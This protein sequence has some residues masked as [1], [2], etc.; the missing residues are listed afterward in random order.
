MYCSQCGAKAAGK[1]CSGCGAPLLA[2]TPG[3]E[4][5]LVDWKN[6]LDY[7][8]LLRVPEVR[9]RIARSAAQCKRHMTGEQFLDICEKAFGKFAGVPLPFATIAQFAQSFHARLGIKTGKSRSQHFTRPPGE[10]LVAILCSL[11]EH[12][13]SLVKAQQVSDGCVL[14]AELPSDL[15]AL[16]GE[17]IIAV[18]SQ[19]G[20]ARVDANTEIPGQYFDWGKSTRCLE[21]LFGE[22]VSGVAA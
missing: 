15:F 21:Q 3:P 13:R 1:F 2:L 9:D 4:L 5:V 12:G 18:S 22:L 10:V 16:R 7:E 20:G 8:A 11:A 6:S 17:L 14:T 19:A